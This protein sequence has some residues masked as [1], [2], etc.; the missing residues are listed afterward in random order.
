MPR[1]PPACGGP[2][3]RRKSSQYGLDRLGH[4]CA[5]RGAPAGRDGDSRSEPAKAPPVLIA[6]RTGCVTPKPLVI[7]HQQVAVKLDQALHTPPITLGKRSWQD[8]RGSS[9]WAAPA[10]IAWWAI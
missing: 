9:I 2:W 6:P 8:L 7:A 4:T 3:A 1:R 10:E 5:T